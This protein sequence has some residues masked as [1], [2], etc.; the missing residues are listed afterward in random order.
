[1]V[2]LIEGRVTAGP[3]GGILTDQVVDVYPF[4]REWIERK[5][6]RGPDRCLVLVRVQGDSMSPTISAGELVL[7]DCRS[8]ER[9]VVKPGRIYLARLPDGSIALKRLV[10]VESGLAAPPRLLALS[11]N[12]NYQPFDFSLDMDRELGYYILG[13][14][15]W[16]GKEFD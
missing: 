6:G 16:A 7:V 11:D 8:A 4:R 3:D 9:Q 15:R 14:I 12:P 5:F 10:L 13:R 2:P 1:M